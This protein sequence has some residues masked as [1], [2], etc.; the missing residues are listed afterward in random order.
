[1]MLN[2]AGKEARGV[3]ETL[4]WTTKTKSR[5]TIHNGFTDDAPNLPKI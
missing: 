5:G 1:M 2:H 4:E 3:Y